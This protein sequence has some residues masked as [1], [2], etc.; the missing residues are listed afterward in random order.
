MAL[1]TFWIFVQSI[2]FFLF[3][4]GR[5]RFC[6][7]YPRILV[8]LSPSQFIYIL[9]CRYR[10]K[11]LIYWQNA[12]DNVFALCLYVN[13]SDFCI[14][15]MENNLLARVKNSQICANFIP[16]P[17]GTNP[18]T[19]RGRVI[20]PLAM[21]IPWMSLI[22]MWVETGQTVLT[23]SDRTHLW[24]HENHNWVVLVPTITKNNIDLNEITTGL[25]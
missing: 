17:N 1:F 23:A 25:C 19:C 21:Y 24:W 10:K 15:S 2:L 12:N 14:K 9:I 3:Y 18:L 5:R 20:F 7:P 16:W 6:V 4:R 13:S 11:R 8:T 22:P